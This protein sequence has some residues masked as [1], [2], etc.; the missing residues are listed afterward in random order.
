MERGMKGRI[1]EDMFL[2]I[3]AMLYSPLHADL[4]AAAELLAARRA[5]ELLMEFQTVD[6]LEDDCS[7]L[8]PII[9][10]IKGVLRSM[11]GTSL[12][13]VHREANN[14][15]HK[16]ACAGL[17]VSSEDR[18]VEPPPYFILDA[19]LEDNQV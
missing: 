12:N 1:G 2:G 18:W 5:A 17:G 16:L 4:L 6:C 15:A 3:F 14:I 9:N 7:L 8:G 10:D 19:L 13:F 11:E